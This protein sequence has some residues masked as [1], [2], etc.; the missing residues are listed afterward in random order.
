[1]SDQVVRTTCS[2]CSV[3][4]N[5]DVTISDAEVPALTPSADYPVNLGKS[6]PKGFHLLKPFRSDDRAADPLLRD[7]AGN[8]VPTDWDTAMREFTT[9]FKSIQEAHGP[10][11]VAFI[12]TGQIPMEEMALLGAVAKFGMGILHG[13]GNTR[14]CMATAAVAYKQAFGFDAPPFSYKDFEE[15]DLLIFIGANPMISHP[16]MWNRVRMNKLDHKVVI[17]DPRRTKSAAAASQHIGLA[18]KS[19]LYLL[20]G[21]AK[22]LIDNDWMDRDFINKHTTG[23]DAFANHVAAFDLGLVTKETGLSAEEV[24]GLARDISKAKAVSMWWTMGVNQSHQAVRTAQAIINLCL[25]T[26]N[27]GKPGTGPNSITGQANAMG[28]RLFSNTTSLFAGYAF[29]EEADRQRIAGI[30]DI[31]VNLIPQQ[32]SL[33]YH[34]ILEAV[35]SG[36]IKGLWVIATNPAHSWINKNDFFRVLE[37]LDFLVVQDLYATTETAQLADLFLPAAGSG[38]KNGTFINSERRLGV[39]QKVME[40]PGNAL[41]DFDIV[42]KVANAW[43]CGDMFTNWKTPEEVF[44]LLQKSSSGRPCDF[45]GIDGYADLVKRRGIQWPYPADSPDQAPERRLFANGEFFTPDRKARILFEDVAEV[46]EAPDEAYPFVLITGRGNVAQFHT[47][48]RTGKVEMLN[49]ISPSA[50]GVQINPSDADRLKIEDGSPVGVRSRR[51]AVVA[52]ADVTDAVQ[53]GQVFMSMHF[54]ETNMLTFPVF[55]PFSGEPGY[56][57]AAVALEAQ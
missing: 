30:L 43:G 35:D 18:P 39:V 53:P 14:Q 55:D 23:F 47:R 28:S 8:L 48:T 5:F 24:E 31:E 11:S 50:V 12:S 34:K 21:L 38:E 45:T 56:K 37:K 40:P 49:R 44:R 17:V 2:Y 36:S 16:I 22:I 32:N 20:Y 42:H 25:I 33:P 15:S 29:T 51:G 9:R 1:M 4:C 57:Y 46:P 19:D 7:P 27:I 41:S 10:E 6:C 54:V 52:T 13:D 3:G 26:G